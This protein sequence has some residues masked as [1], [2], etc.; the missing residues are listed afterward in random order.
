[1]TNH[2][3][4]S[5]ATYDPDD[6]KIRMYPND[7]DDRMERE[8]WEKLCRQMKFQKA[9]KQGCYF[10]VWTYARKEFA[11]SWCGEIVREGSTLEERATARALRFDQH[12]MNR[13]ADSNTYLRSAQQYAEQSNNQPILSGHHSER[14]METAEKRRKSAEANAIKNRET[15]NYWLQKATGVERHAN[16]M[17]SRKLVEGRIETI[18]KDMR[19]YQRRINHANNMVEQ[20]GTLAICKL[21]GRQLHAYVKHLAGNHYDYGAAIPANCEF[22]YDNI[23]EDIHLLNDEE[24]RDHVCRTIELAWG[25]VVSSPY[26]NESIEHCLNRLAYESGKFSNTPWYDGNITAAVI[27]T[28]ARKHGAEKPKARKT[29]DDYWE[30]ETESPLPI[31]WGGNVSVSKTDDEW[32]EFMNDLYYEVPQKAPAKAPILNFEIPGGTLSVKQWG[33]INKMRQIKM[34]KQEYM[35]VHSDQRGVTMHQSG[36]FRVKFCK[37]PNTREAGKPWS[38]EWCVVLLTDSKVHPIP[39]VLTTPSS[40]ES[41]A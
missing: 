35:N 14:K 5:H 24:V 33:N 15:A 13:Y 40:C 20:W 10:A 22:T 41:E 32:R 26:L 4:F 25:D 3:H 2:S 6:N 37:D 34:T 7:I 19:G 12:A 1:M 31:H 38:G 8:D 17:Q 36:T 29:E 9:Y 18:L 27:Q 11:V 30:L 21:E 23:K 16:R 28:F 39:E